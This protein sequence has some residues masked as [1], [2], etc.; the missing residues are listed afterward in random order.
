[1]CD[2]GIDSELHERL[3]QALQELRAAAGRVLACE[4]DP[5]TP[6]A[7]AAFAALRQACVADPAAFAA[8]RPPSLVRIIPMRDRSR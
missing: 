3:R 1:M 7:R 4:A 6:E 2:D 8:R 5:T